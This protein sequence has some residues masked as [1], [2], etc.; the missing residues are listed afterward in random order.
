MVMPYV[1]REKDGSLSRITPDSR[2]LE[3]LKPWFP[4]PERF[5]HTGNSH[6]LYPFS[7]SKMLKKLYDSLWKP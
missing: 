2:R 3:Y 7:A 1:R 6:E 5:G 4:L